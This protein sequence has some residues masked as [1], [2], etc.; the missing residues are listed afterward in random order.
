MQLFYHL[1]PSIE[2]LSTLNRCRM[3]LQV[4]YVSEICTGDGNAISEHAWNGLRFEISHRTDSWPRYQRPYPRE[5]SLWQLFL[6]KTLVHRGLRLKRPLGK[7]LRFTP[8]WEW[9]YSPS[10]ECLFQQTEGKWLSFSQ[11]LKRDRLP[12][13]TN[14]GVQAIPPTDACR[15][16][17]YHN[18]QRI[19]CTGYSPILSQPPNRAD[20]FSQY[21][22]GAVEGEK[23]CFAHLDMTDDGTILA[24]AIS[25]GDAITISDG[26]FQDTYGTA[27]WVLE[28]SD[29][30][31]RMRGAVIVP[32]N[33]NDQSAYRS[34]LA[35]IYSILVAVTKLCNFFDIQQGAIELGCDGQSALDKAFNHVALIRIEDANHDLLQAIRSLWACSSIQWKFRHVR[36]HQDDHVAAC[37]L[38]RWA[39]LNI[40]MDAYAK[41]H[42]QIARSSPRHF[43]VAYEPWSIWYQGKKIT[44]D[45]SNTVYDLVHS[46][47]V[48]EYWCR[49]D[50]LQPEVVE[51]VSWEA[52]DKAMLE[53]KRSRRVFISKHAC[54]MCG[55]GKFMK[56]WKQRSDDACPRCGETEDSAHVWVCNGSGADEVWERSV[57]DLKRWL[58]TIQTDPDIQHCIISYLHSWRY[59]STVDGLSHFPF[60]SYNES[61]NKIG[62]HRFF[63]GWISLEWTRAQHA[64]YRTIKSLRNGK[65]WTISLIKKLWDIAW[66]LWQH[67]NG[68]LHDSLNAVSDAE[69]RAL[70]RKVKDTFCSLQ[71]LTLPANDRHLVKT[72][73]TQLLKKDKTYKEAW[74][75]NATIVSARRCTSQ[76]YKRH[77]HEVLIRGMQRCM[78]RN[79]CV[80][81]RYCS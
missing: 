56:R 46:A 76:W 5:W 30:A 67:R 73:L 41:Q 45:F 44:S 61:Q 77:S 8:E 29:S 48:K 19:I 79:M 2:D 12:T 24:K 66:D 69:L 57:E 23:W 39:I 31:G 60:T 64:Y 17:I 4:N 27:A 40:E 14:H 13:F 63:E 42:M 21:I 37:E 32:G 81:P 80:R 3:Y 50:N 59:N 10:Q 6:K 7:W 47:E 55:V 71:S 68:I 16:T 38:D 52:I 18:R 49:K 70:D 22:K 9:Y 62:W 65:R 1:N 58:N 43:K 53:T 20:T 54:G 15:A 34:E 26:S 36:G 51:A 11:V 78:R 75:H 33:A 74:L 28:G 25:Q 72:P 35:G